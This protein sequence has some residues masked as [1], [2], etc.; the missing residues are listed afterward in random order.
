MGKSGIGTVLAFVTVVGCHSATGPELC[1]Q[2]QQIHDAGVC[3][4]FSSAGSLVTYRDVLEQ[5]VGRTLDVVQ[6]LLGVSDLRI[7]VIADPGQVIPEVGL[8]GFNPGPHEVRLYADPSWPNL[9]TVLR[10]EVM[11]TL[12]HEIHH[13]MRRRAVGYGSTLLQAAVTEGLADHFSIE[14]SGLPAPPWATA[15]TREELDRLLPELLAHR[16][17]PYDHGT[18]FFGTGSEIP[19]WTGYAVGFEL[20]RRYLAENAGFRASSLVGEPASSFVPPGS[21]L[22]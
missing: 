16:T 10:T 7:A 15:L 21:S 1:E 2:A 18:W 12:A 17:G 9:E 11:R 14:V 13:A 6:P 22:P 19:R 3:L 8:G 4:D 20:V 5:E